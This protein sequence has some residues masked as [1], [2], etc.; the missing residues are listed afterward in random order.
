MACVWSHLEGLWY[1]M[2]KYWQSNASFQGDGIW[3]IGLIRGIRLFTEGLLE[4]LL[5]SL[6]PLPTM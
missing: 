5:F 3:E 2:A 6:S 1:V 4:S